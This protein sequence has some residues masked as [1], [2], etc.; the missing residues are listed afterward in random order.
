MA[1]PKFPDSPL[2]VDDD[3]TGLRALPS[4]PAVYAFVIATFFVWVV[5]LTWLSRAFL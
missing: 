1:D 2:A 4:W 3:Q 5:F